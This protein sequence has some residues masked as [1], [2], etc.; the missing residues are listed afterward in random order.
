MSDSTVTGDEDKVVE[1]ED[2]KAS[3]KRPHVSSS[4]EDNPVNVKLG[5]KG[6]D[7]KLVRPDA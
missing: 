2:S 6:R 4:D 1:V 7:P 5:L 3:S